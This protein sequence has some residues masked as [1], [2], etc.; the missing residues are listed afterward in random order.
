VSAATAVR[1]GVLALPATV[2]G[3]RAVADP[4]EDAVTLAAEAALPVVERADEPPRALVL[5]TLTPP[6]DEG[7]SVQV[8]AELLGLAGE[9]VTVELTASVKDGLTAL[10]VAGALV[11]AGDGP[12]LVVASHRGGGQPEAGDG[13]VA[14]LVGPPPGVAEV[15]P[16]RAHAEELRD[17]WRLAGSPERHEGDPSFV[18][19][20]GVPRVARAFETSPA[21]VVA[22]AL[23]AAAR[24]E[25]A[26]GGPGDDVA[27]R[28]GHLGAAHPLARILVGLDMVR[29]LVAGGSGLVEH[30]SVEPGQGAAET[31]AAARASLERPRRSTAPPDVDWSRLAPYASGPRAWRERGQELR[32][33]GGRCGACAQLVF[34]RPPTCPTCGSRALAAER[35]PRTGTVVTETRDHVYPAARATGMAVVDLD[36][37]GRFYGQVVPSGEAAIGDRVRLVPRRLHDGGGAA[38]YFWKVAPDADRG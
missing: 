23:K 15:R 2:V 20:H 4:D 1:D 28:V 13:A 25:R 33:E 11:A 36:G 24:A 9:L 5:A 16:G 37:G 34:P 30:V 17:R 22:P 21:A 26:L 12:V 38:Q 19:D 31:A 18:W 7:G 10:R 8:L 6:Y 14:L 27:G 35:L 29:D 32:L 3:G